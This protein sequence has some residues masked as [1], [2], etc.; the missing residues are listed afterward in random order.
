MIQ[1]QKQTVSR[2]SNIRIRQLDAE[3]CRGNVQT[4][5]NGL[6]WSTWTERKRNALTREAVTPTRYRR[7][8]RV[9]PLGQ[10]ITSEKEIGTH[11][12]TKCSASS[13]SCCVGTNCRMDGDRHQRCQVERQIAMLQSITHKIQATRNVWDVT[14]CWS[15]RERRE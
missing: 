1:S 3:A 6:D 10:Y 14:R 9:M 7:D 2:K 4:A 12:V 11:A 15:N 5:R 13:M 8:E